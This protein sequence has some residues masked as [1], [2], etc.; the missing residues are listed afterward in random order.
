MGGG[1]SLEVISGMKELQNEISNLRNELA[2]TRNEMEEQ[3]EW[4]LGKSV[5]LS[6]IN[7]EYVEY[8]YSHGFISGPVAVI[9]MDTYFKNIAPYADFRLFR[10]NHHPSHTISIHAV[11]TSGQFYTVSLDTGGDLTFHPRTNSGSFNARCQLTFR[12]SE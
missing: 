2:E 9:T 11:A 12:I 1:T 8:D 6:E 5:E 10:M 7:T 3:K 4:L